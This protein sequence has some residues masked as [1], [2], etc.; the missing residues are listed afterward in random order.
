M[1]YHTYDVP[2]KCIREPDIKSAAT[3]LTR[4]NTSKKFQGL[5][6]ETLCIYGHVAQGATMLQDLK[7]ESSKKMTLNELWCETFI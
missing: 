3:H 5:P 6:N 7:V 4:Y 2:T 1:H